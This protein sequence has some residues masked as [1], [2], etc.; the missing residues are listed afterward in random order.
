MD[1]LGSF[2]ESSQGEMGIGGAEYSRRLEA[3][4]AQ[5]NSPREIGGAEIDSRWKAHS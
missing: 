1:T 2:Q 3:C 4:Q 5:Q